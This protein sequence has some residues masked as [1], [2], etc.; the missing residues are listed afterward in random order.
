MLSLYRTPPNITNK[1]SQKSSNTN[2]D[3]YSNHEHDLKWSQMSPKIL[4]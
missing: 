4:K 2:L 3:D 1:R